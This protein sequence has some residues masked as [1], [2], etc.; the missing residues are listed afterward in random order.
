MRKD[1]VRN[2]RGSFQPEERQRYGHE[3]AQRRAKGERWTSIAYDLGISAVTLRRWGKFPPSP[4]APV[5]I[6][7]SNARLSLPTVMRSTHHMPVL[8]TPE[9]LRIEGLTVPDL[10]DV[11]KALR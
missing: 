5:V 9:G 2:H 4:F 10:I 11:L 7:Q 1:R 6:E 8:I 3:A